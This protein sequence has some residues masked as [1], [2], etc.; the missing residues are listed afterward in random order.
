MSNL[1][2]WAREQKQKSL[3]KIYQQVDEDF[4]KVTNKLTKEVRSFN[5][6]KRIIYLFKYFL[7]K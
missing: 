5:I 7:N 2:K 3:E 1:E 4:L 6:I